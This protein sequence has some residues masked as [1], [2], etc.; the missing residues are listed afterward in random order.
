MRILGIHVG[1]HDSAACLFKDEEML[2][3]CKEERLTRIKNC[4]R[5]FKLLSIDEVLS[6]AGMSRMDVDAV[7]LSRYHLPSVCFKSKDRPLVEL[8]RRLR[9]RETNRKLFRVMKKLENF[10]EEEIVDKAAIRKFLKLRP[11]VDVHFANHHFSHVLG[12]FHYTDWDKDALFISCDGGG[13]FAYYSAY[14]YDGKELRNVLGGNLDSFRTPQNEGASIGLAYCSTTAFLGFM[15]NRHEGKVTGL[16]AFGEPVAADDILAMFEIKEDFRIE[17]SINYSRSDLNAS[18]AKIFDKHSKED[19]ASSIQHATESLVSTWVSKLLKTHPAKYIGMSG[20]VFS[21]VLL[22]Q[23][24]A[25]LPKVEDTFVFPPMGDEGLPVGN[26]V[27]YLIEKNGLERLNRR[28]MRDVYLG[29]PYPPSSLIETA[30]SK[31]LFVRKTANIAED[32]ASLLK[33]HY[34]GALFAERMEMG[35]RALGARSILANPSDREINDS[36]NKRL[37]R[38]EFMP[39]APYVL[40]IDAERIFDVPKH[41]V[42]PSRFMTITVNVKEEHRSVIPAVVHI[43][44][45]ARPQ[46]VYR[47]DNPIYYDILEAFKEATGIPC[48]VNT[49]FNAHE[50]PIINTPAEAVNALIHDRVDF[51]ICDDALIFKT[52]EVAAKISAS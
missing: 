47:G 4:G 36:I 50:E 17:S 6:I 18:L 48:L 2:A 26:C 23:K 13:D 20:G 9:G 37:G 8:S 16:A 30:E 21:N 52:P 27:S 29:R 1:P 46:I 42:Y 24:I 25:E 22:N 38:T 28:K 5:K 19:I 31:G 44:G 32:A 41:S 34:I 45:T 33:Q 11:D 12:A 43:D 35:P 51:L 15:P 3:F 14:H 10:N 40:D 39:F 7:A 49:S